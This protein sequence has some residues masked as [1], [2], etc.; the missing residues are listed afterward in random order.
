MEKRRSAK[1]LAAI[2]LILLL[3]LSLTPV[4][5]AE[6]NVGA[7]QDYN[8]IQDAIDNANTA[9]GDVINVF[10]GTYEEDVVVNKNLTIKVNNNDTVTLKPVD[11]GFNVLND[12]TGNGNGTTITGF[13]INLL[14]NGVGMNISA[15]DVTI[16]D[17]T[18]NGGKKGIITLGN[19]TLIKNNKISCASNTSIQAGEFIIKNESGNVTIDSKI[20]NN[21]LIDNNQITGGLSGIVVLGDNNSITRNNISNVLN[22]GIGTAGSNPVISGNRIMDMVGNG[23]K[24]GITV[25]SLNFQGI[26]G[27]TMTGNILTKI[28]STDNKTTGIDIFTMT[29]DSPLD[30]I[31]VNKNTV[32]YIYGIG[33]TTAMSIV[34]LALK[35]AMS[36]L[37]VL[38]NAIT[39][40]TSQ[41]ENSTS[42]GIFC[43]PMG[44]DSN[45][46]TTKSEN[47]T[48]SKNNITGIFSIGENSQTT[49]IMYL[50]IAQG[51]STIS[52]NEISQ[53][54]ANQAIGLFA[55]GVDY[56]KFQANMTINKNSITDITATNLKSGIV[57]MNMGNIFILHNNLFRLDGDKTRYITAQPV[58]VGNVTIMGNNLEGSGKEIGIAVNGNHTTISYNRITNFQFYI[59]NMYYMEIFEQDP[60]TD[61]QLR[62]YIRS[63]YGNI[64]EEQVDQIIIAYHK[65]EDYKHSIPSYTDARYN[66]FGT[67]RDP[68]RNKFLSGNGT[69]NYDPWL[70]LS[71]HAD[72]S[73]IHV[74]GKSVITADVYQDSAGGDHSVNAAKFFSGPWVTFTTNLGNIGSKII[75]VD[76]V[77]GLAMAILRGDEGPGIAT[78][79]ASDYQT[80]QTFITILGAPEPNP[81]F[82]DMEDTGAPVNYLLM[83]FVLLLGGLGL[84]RRK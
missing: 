29:M 21:T 3:F 15:G 63:Q 19:N 75:T 10:N 70:I 84:S 11:I 23:S 60:F 54:E 74:G 57:A 46:N 1:S 25:A 36:S 69:I 59:K 81:D 26:T 13:I 72:P 34:T 67:N 35:G 43:L 47:L 2:F 83:A 27:L 37:K 38:E 65:W 77:N 40:V 44:F 4:S 6:W 50:Q 71:I 48:I 28:H 12:I 56:T 32:K 61:E 7:G 33:E 82:I 42:K 30:D 41:G 79:T 9:D 62:D 18:I 17:N 51:N 39:N 64:T 22:V 58:A 66:W 20:A 76:W 45:N 14:F 55:L 8:N 53:I 52:E 16:T 73:T 49:G 5:A 78:V 68:G 80:V 31:L 24:I